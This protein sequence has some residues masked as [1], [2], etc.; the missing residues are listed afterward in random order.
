M[1]VVSIHCDHAQVQQEHKANTCVFTLNVNRQSASEIGKYQ[2][3]SS[4]SGSCHQ[5]HSK[6]R[7]KL[8]VHSFTFTRVECFR[9][10]S[11]HVSPGWFSALTGSSSS[12]QDSKQAELKVFAKPVLPLSRFVAQL[13]S[14]SLHCL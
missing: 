10:R 12:K 5:K 6:R 14:C 3:L 9:W 2:R 1:H 13:E 7:N 11:N 8:N 4:E